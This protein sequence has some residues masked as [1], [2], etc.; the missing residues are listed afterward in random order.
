[1]RPRMCELLAIL[2]VSAVFVPVRWARR[3]SAD[4]NCSPGRM[5]VDSRG[6]LSC[7]GGRPL[8]ALERLALGWAVPIEAFHE[9]DWIALYG[10]KAGS[11]LARE[12]AGLSPC[13]ALRVLQNKREEGMLGWLPEGIVCSPAFPGDMAAGP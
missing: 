7:S 8:K 9:N 10:K 2:F 5:R 6:R 11:A 3:P 12:I 13:A 1:M 4:V